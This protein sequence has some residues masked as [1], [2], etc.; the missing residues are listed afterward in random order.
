MKKI[1]LG[2]QMIFSLFKKYFSYYKG[3]SIKT[4]LILISIFLYAQA[5]PCVAFLPLYLHQNLNY[6][7]NYTG[8]ILSIFGFGTVLGSY[9]GGR[10][11]DKFSPGKV[12]T[13]SILSNI[14]MLLI[15]YQFTFSGFLLIIS[16]F[17]YSLTNSSFSPASRIFL[18]KSVPEVDQERINGIRYM[19]F[20]VGSSISFGFIGWITEGNYRKV[21]LYSAIFCLFSVLTLFFMPAIKSN[22]HKVSDQK[23]EKNISMVKKPNIPVII[24][25]ISIFLGMLVFAQMNSSYILFLANK[26][27]FKSSQ[28]GF[29]F[30]INSLII[31]IFQVPILKLFRNIDAFL[32]LCIGSLVMGF[33]FFLLSFHIGTSVGILSM[34][35]ITLG[36]ILFMPTSQNIVYQSARADLKGSYV[37][38]YQALSSLTLMLTP[39]LS[40]ILLSKNDNGL[41]LWPL[42]FFLCITPIAYL[43]ISKALKRIF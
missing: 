34:L 14:I 23:Q 21:F 19:I 10:L 8:V 2:T 9:Y 1:D 35:L 3:I 36:E 5:Y 16:I 28:V 24:I 38:V 30:F 7:M 31:G 33:G 27:Y 17:M 26:Y 37:G 41:F 11:C 25:F 20:N 4:T 22:R 43:G 15:S 40:G 18:M 12:S 6:S 32:L 29:L 13:I 42:S 39:F